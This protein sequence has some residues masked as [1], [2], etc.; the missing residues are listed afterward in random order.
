[1]L[2][3]DGSNRR[4][5]DRRAAPAGR[6]AG[7]TPGRTAAAATRGLAACAAAAAA[8]AGRGRV[9]PSAVQQLGRHPR[10]DSAQAALDPRLELRRRARL[11]RAQQAAERVARL[12]QLGGW[13]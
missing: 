11:G 7:R 6:T 13:G 9:A 4:C 2:R 1:V 10:A 8:A 5:R 3:G 12:D